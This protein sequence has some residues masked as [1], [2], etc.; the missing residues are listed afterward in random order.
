M[1]KL[2]LFLLLFPL[3]SWGKDYYI[4]GSNV[5]GKSWELA[6]KDA[7]F[8]LNESGL[9]E[10]SGSYLLMD[11]K[12]NDGTWGEIDFGSN[13]E[14]II[15]GEPYSLNSYS[16]GHITSEDYLA[17]KDPKIVLDEVAQTI[18]LTGTGVP[19]GETEYY[20]IGDNVNGR[21]WELAAQDCKFRQIGSEL[22]EWTGVNLKTGFKI[23]SGSWYPVN[24]GSS[25]YELVIGQEYKY[26]SDSNSQNIGFYNETEIINPKVVLNLANQ[27]ILVTVNTVNLTVSLPENMR[28]EKYRGSSVELID[29]T[30]EARQLVDLNNDWQYKFIGLIK[31]HAYRLRLYSNRGLLL[32]EIPIVPLNE[33]ENRIVFES[34]KE[35]FPVSVK[36]ADNEGNDVTCE[37][38]VDWY[39]ITDGTRKTIGRGTALDAVPVGTVLNGHVTLSKPLAKKYNIPEDFQITISD[40]DN[41]HEISLIPFNYTTINGK[42]CGIGNQPLASTT[43]TASQILNGNKNIAVTSTDSN[44]LWELEVTESQLVEICYECQDHVKTIMTI[45][46]ENMGTVQEVCLK[47]IEGHQIQLNVELTDPDTDSKISDYELSN[48]LV[49]KLKNL[50]TGMEIDNVQ[51]QYPLLAI[52]ASS[53]SFGDNIQLTLESRTNI[54]DPII[55]EFSITDE[56]KTNVSAYASLYG[57]IKASYKTA[58]NPDV[59]AYLYDSNGKLYAQDD[60][61]DNQMTFGHIHDGS[62]TVVAM[63]KTTAISDIYNLEAYSQI[64]LVESL[65]YLIQDVSIQSGEV[66][67]VDFDI[68]PELD[69]LSNLYTTTATSFT[70][71]KTD[72]VTG[73]YITYRSNIE[74]KPYMADKIDNATLVIEFPDNISYVNNSVIQGSK[75]LTATFSRG[76]LSIPISDFQTPVKM[77]AVPWSDGAARVNAF[78]DFKLN[79]TRVKQPIGTT[80]TEVSRIQIKAPSVISKNTFHVTGATLP[81]STVNIYEESSLIGTTVAN[82]AGAWYAECALPEDYNLSRHNIHAEIQT[83][84][85]KTM[86]SETK[87]VFLNKTAIEVAKV[88]MRHWNPEMSREYVSVFDFQ[89]PHQV[90]NHW[91]LYY[92]DKTFTYTIEFTD[93]NPDLIGNV[94]LYVHLASDEIEAYPAHYDADKKL[95]VARC[96][97]G[98][99]N[100]SRYPVNCSVDFDSYA[101]MLL[102]EQEYLDGKDN[103]TVLFEDYQKFMK[104]LESFAAEGLNEGTELDWDKFF[105]SN[106]LD[107]DASTEDFK[108]PDEF[109]QWSETRQNEYFDSLF[110]DFEKEESEINGELERIVKSLAMDPSNQ[111]TTFPDGTYIKYSSCNGL[112]PEQLINDGFELVETLNGAAVYV[113]NSGNVSVFV[114]LSNDIYIESGFDS[115]KKYQFRAKGQTAIDALNAIYSGFISILDLRDQ[116][117]SSDFNSCLSVLSK[118]K[119][120]FET[121]GIKLCPTLDEIRVDIEVALN[122]H[123]SKLKHQKAGYCSALSKIT[124]KNSPL[125]IKYAQ[126]IAA[127]N[128]CIAIAAKSKTAIKYVF[129]T[130]AKNLP[131]AG[132]IAEVADAINDIRKLKKAYDK[133]SFSICPALKNLGDYLLEKLKEKLAQRML[134]VFEQ[135]VT[136]AISDVGITVGIAASLETVGISLSASAIGIIIKTIGAIGSLAHDYLLDKWFEEF[137]KELRSLNCDEDED[138]DEK[139][140]SKGGKHQSRSP[141]DNT[142]VDP[143]GF[144]YEAVPSNRLQDVIASIFYKE[145]RTDQYGDAYDEVSLWNADDFGQINPQRTDANGLY[146]WDV[147]Q[148]MWQVKFEKPGYETTSSDW[149]PVPPPQLEVNIP[150]VQ[151]KQPEVLEAHAHPSGVKIKFDKYLDESTL[152]TSNIS[153][154]AGS[155][156]I[157]GSIELLD[158]ETVNSGDGIQN[159]FSSMLRFVP[160]S[161]LNAD[162]KEVSLSISSNVKS[163]SGINLREPVSMTLPV[164]PEITELKTDNYMAEYGDII[165]VEVLALPANASVGKR[166]VAYASSDAIISIEDCDM[167][168]DNEGRVIIPVKALL[169]GNAEISF[170]I[171]DLDIQTKAQVKVVEE[172]MVPDAPE[173]SIE[174][175]TEVF[176]GSKISLSAEKSCDI[177]YTTDGTDPS[178]ENGTRRKYLIPITIKDDTYIRTVAEI[179]GQAVSDIADY[180]YSIVRGNIDIPIKKGWNWV[181]HP[182]ISSFGIE[183]T[184]LLNSI[185]DENG[186]VDFMAIL[187]FLYSGKTLKVNATDSFI[188]FKNDILWNPANSIIVNRGW[189]WIPYPI[190]N[191]LAID[192]AIPYGVAEKLDVIVGQYGF[193]QYDGTHWTG[194]LKSLTPGHGYMYVSQSDKAIHFN[195][196]GNNSLKES[197]ADNNLQSPVWTNAYP[198]VMPMMV[199]IQGNSDVDISDIEVEAYGNDGIRGKAVAISSNCLFLS[200]YGNESES[201]CFRATDRQSNRTFEAS[202]EVL[203]TEDVYGSIENPYTLHI[204]NTVSVNDLKK[205]NPSIHVDN[206]YLLVDGINPTDIKLIEI[207][208]PVGFCMISNRNFPDKGLSLKSLSKNIYLVRITTSDGEVLNK[209]IY[210]N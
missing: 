147:P 1:K 57:S 14:S 133:I 98:S 65:D 149:L 8:S 93:N 46:P 85:G 106:N 138:D 165:D 97:L 156:A 153:L 186:E 144:V 22:Y 74:F 54:F 130:L 180:N 18:T 45:E 132:W 167:V 158:S 114:D 23:N 104:N 78:I 76:Q 83:S 205:A 110:K 60:F 119:D 9:Y 3:I 184:A 49:I 196:S 193:S 121:F 38:T 197:V 139:D 67:S 117:N 75:M 31:D 116:W 13:G 182:F 136:N 200:V 155:T 94:V 90:G 137:S 112:T 181:S 68:I 129:K 88:T 131:V 11:F 16:Q 69:E 103:M 175:E 43:V 2:L 64:G 170:S 187:D 34:I 162:I 96:N 126:K 123:L 55:T 174:S 82:G 63:G 20:I 58:V 161:P 109:D 84:D 72:V 190:A 99:E 53:F 210:M 17:V 56:S 100:N 28:N 208:D 192:T 120:R 105:D 171:E 124:D 135:L 95:W 62:Y 159:K 47:S 111:E 26:F 25:G 143:S 66:V 115:S 61:R 189:N 35:M 19:Y 140:K 163:Y 29:K 5:N 70:T 107:I 6:D 164:E 201:I 37:T 176:Y 101:P 172:I 160:N 199:S 148:G 152:T 39:E 33:T 50:A 185:Y 118:V 206:E 4:I 36:I 183:N 168:F 141:H 177:Y 207:I 198:C 178:D 166:L 113:K 81:N 42:V 108:L 173:A 169:P 41:T 203:I 134:M 87:E 80:I 188:I 179:K 79:E 10:W 142:L 202:E 89:N 204:S 40:T 71:N 15:L 122:A 145:T 24:I 125:A 151:S 52:P 191:T 59:I 7:K 51:I 157:V 27:T 77:C 44:G 195:T 150:M 127:L 30:T 91:T 92:P 194:T 128:N 21:H 154:K 209:K 12:I 146:R 86:K 102:D 48:S 32:D 73:N